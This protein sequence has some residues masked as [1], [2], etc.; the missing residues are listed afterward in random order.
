EE[1][2]RHQEWAYAIRH[3]N[4]GE[5]LRQVSGRLQKL[6]PEITEFVRDSLTP[7]LSEDEKLRLKHDFDAAAKPGQ[8]VQVLTTLVELSDK[9]PLKYPP[10]PK[11]GPIQWTDLR[12]GLQAV[13]NKASDTPRA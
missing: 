13:L 11:I 2:L 4:E 3:W 8:W 1:R 12:A 7:L 9:H 10:P 5:R 6:K